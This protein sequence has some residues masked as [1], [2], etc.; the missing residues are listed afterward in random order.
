MEEEEE[1]WQRHCQVN[2]Y[3]STITP[4]SWNNL[5]D[6]GNPLTRSPIKIYNNDKDVWETAELQECLDK[7]EF[8]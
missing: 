2:A 5:D 6:N 1:A 7:A 8:Y 4:S 3:L